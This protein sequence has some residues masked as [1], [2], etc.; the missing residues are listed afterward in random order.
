MTKKTD[1]THNIV[2]LKLR[3]NFCFCCGPDNPE[4]MH[5]KFYFDEPNRRT[6]CNFKLSRRYQ[7]PPGHAHG[8][9]IAT[10]LDDAMGKVNKMRSVVALTKSMTVEYMRPVPLGE[11]L[12]VEGTEEKVE[13][14]KHTNIAAIKNEAGEVLARSTG[15]FIAIDAE[16]MFAKHLKKG[17]G[18]G[19]LANSQPVR[20]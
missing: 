16:A 18:S 14:R 7:G 15:L 13:G 17:E 8:G 20:E 3:K 4:G 10:I 1:H 5:L 9:I 2:T 12:L 11:K 19:P 6:Y